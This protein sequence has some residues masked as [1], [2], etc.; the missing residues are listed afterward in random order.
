MSVLV[1]FLPATS[2]TFGSKAQYSWK[3]KA[4][5]IDPINYYGVTVQMVS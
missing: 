2:F 1:F 3:V 5:K 4:E